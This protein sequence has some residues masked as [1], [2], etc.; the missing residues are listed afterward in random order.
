MKI[1]MAELEAAG[2]EDKFEVKDSGMAKTLA[3]FPG[4]GQL[5]NT[6]RGQV[7]LSFR[8]SL[9]LKMRNKLANI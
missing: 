8:T 2:C 4:G 9:C 5:Y 7:S 3:V 6:L 1:R